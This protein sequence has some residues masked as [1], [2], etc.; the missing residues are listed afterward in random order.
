MTLTAADPKDGSP[1]VGAPEG[2]RMLAPREVFGTIRCAKAHVFWRSPTLITFS[3][4]TLFLDRPS[5]GINH[6]S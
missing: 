2:T 1:L 4:F 6:Q 5:D 3:L